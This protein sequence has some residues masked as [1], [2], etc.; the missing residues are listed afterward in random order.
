VIEFETGVY[1][2]SSRINL[3]KDGVTLRGKQ[4]QQVVFK[5]DGS[6]DSS[7]LT[8]GIG[9]GFGTAYTVFT[10]N[11]ADVMKGSSNIS[12]T[13]TPTGIAVDDI[14]QID[15]LEDDT[16]GEAN[17]LVDASGDSGHCDWCG[18][19]TGSRPFSQTLRVVAIN[20]TTNITFEPPLFMD[21]NIGQT[22]QIVEQTSPIRMAGIESIIVSNSASSTDTVVL[23]AGY[24]CFIKD[25]TLRNSYRRAVS[26]TK[27]LQNSFTGNRFEDGIGGDWSTGYGPD[28]GYGM[29]V[30]FGSSHC[31]IE[32]NIFTKLSFCVAMEGSG[33]GTV[34]GYNFATN[35]MNRPADLDTPKYWSGNHGAHPAMVLMEGNYSASRTGMDHYWGSSS[36]WMFLRNR[37]FIVTPQ[38]GT[39]VSQY[40]IVFDVWT[41]NV[42][43]T[44]IGNIFGISGTENKLEPAS[45]DS[46]NSGSSVKAIRRLGNQNVN[47]TTWS[48]YDPTVSNTLRWSV[49][50]L[51]R[52]NTATSGAGVHYDP[53]VAS[54]PLPASL[55]LTNKLPVQG[56]LPWPSH[57]PADITIATATNLAAGY[58]FY[59]GAN[60]QSGNSPIPQP[61]ASVGAGRLRGVRVSSP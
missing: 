17:G 43:H 60:P 38:N 11:I 28:R 15:Q 6:V 32:D 22:I 24:R 26:M 8:I 53:F 4:G 39:A 49:N 20:N 29:F 50:W 47:N 19:S 54:S 30:G 12:V 44:A 57:D 48:Q 41:N 25:C 7:L 27:G 36:H 42:F 3:D 10:N 18:R 23:D 5:N 37:N 9:S 46:V 59:F 13:A 21:F 51:S 35:I 58:R 31:L 52:T 14:V 56:I 16:G 34:I 45:G 2:F 33:L 1:N 61:Q 55:Y 40:W